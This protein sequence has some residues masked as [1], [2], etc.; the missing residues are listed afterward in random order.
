M[1]D[2]EHRGAQP[3]EEGAQ[4]D[5]EPFAQAPVQ[6]AQR[7]V[8]HQQL[9]TGCQRP[10]ERHPLLFTAGQGRD[11][12]SARA[13]QA[14]QVQEFTGP[15]VPLRPGHA[16]RLQPEGDV[17][18]DVPVREQLVVLEHQAQSPPVHGQSRLVGAVQVHP[19][20]VQGLQPGDGPQ[21]RRLAAAAGSQHT[22][23]LVVRDLQVHG[24]QRGPL[25]EPDRGR[26]HC[27]HL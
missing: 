27:Q 8:Q 12:P 22:D 26:L 6:L 9:R 25:P 1:G 5:D 17:G 7:F 10:G 15:A 20:V 11:G 21:E 18:A 3:A 16:V 23:D 24:V 2:G 13:R 4:F 19:P 14:D